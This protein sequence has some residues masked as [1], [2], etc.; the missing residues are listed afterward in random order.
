MMLWV[1]FLSSML[2]LSSITWADPPPSRPFR[3]GGTVTINGVQLTSETDEGYIF[4]ATDIEGNLLAQDTDGLND[5]GS[6]FYWI[7]SPLCEQN[8]QPGVP[9]TRQKSLIHIHKNGKELNIAY[10]VE[11]NKDRDEGESLE[12]VSG[13]EITLGTCGKNKRIDLAVITDMGLSILAL[14]SLTGQSDSDCDVSVCDING[15]QKIGME[16]AIFMLQKLAC[17]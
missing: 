9:T 10:H 1:L 7:D 17:Q 8:E 6:D 3:F 11:Y 4:T 2:F 5:N 13:A 14:K 12:K 15:D 16:D